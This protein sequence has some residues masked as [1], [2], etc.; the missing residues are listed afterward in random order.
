MKQTDTITHYN[1]LIDEGNDP[2]LD[3]PSLQAYMDK[4]DGA[5]FL[6]LLGLNGSQSVLEIGCGTGRLALKIAPKVRSFVGID[7]SEKTVD[8]AKGHVYFKNSEIICGDFLTYEFDRRFDTVCSSLTFMHIKE[9]SA[10]I[11]KTAA[12]LVPNGRFVL[13]ISKDESDVLD[14]GTRTVKLYPD[15]CEETVRMLEES[16]FGAIEVH[17][18]EL[19][20]VIAAVKA[21]LFPKKYF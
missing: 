19:A 3:P 2:V 17:E 6:S 16:G 20:Y 13:S 11:S 12:L 15:S 14:F 18:T 21:M 10:A 8:R 7:I 5:L 1:L 9:K 4:W